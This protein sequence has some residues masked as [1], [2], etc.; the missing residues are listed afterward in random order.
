MKIGD[1]V[2]VKDDV[3][4]PHRGV[5]GLVFRIDKEFYGARQTIKDFNTKRGHVIGRPPYAQ[6]GIGTYWDG[7][8][9]RIL[10]LFDGQDWDYYKSGELEVL[11]ES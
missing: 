10:V 2:R 6:L 5:T 9:S 3:G 11:S 8:Q 1:L 4:D 7:I